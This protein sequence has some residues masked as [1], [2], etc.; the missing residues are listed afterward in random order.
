MKVRSDWVPIPRRDTL[1]DI[2]RACSKL[3]GL[4]NEDE[5]MRRLLED[6]WNAGVRVALDHEERAMNLNPYTQENYIITANT[7]ET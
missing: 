1:I 5:F 6:A 3:R 7:E 2:P 4:R